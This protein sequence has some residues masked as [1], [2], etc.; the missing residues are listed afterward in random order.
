MNRS[1]AVHDA[2]AHSA[3]WLVDATGSTLRLAVG[4]R[5]D[6][7]KPHAWAKRVCDPRTENAGLVMNAVEIWWSRQG[8][9]RSRQLSRWATRP[10]A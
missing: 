7:R 3:P 6:V 1:C 2:G 9:E 4:V 8:A 5:I 10:L